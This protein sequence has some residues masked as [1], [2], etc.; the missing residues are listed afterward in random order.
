MFV[1]CEYANI[2]YPNTFLYYVL[3]GFSH[4]DYSATSIDLNA[5]RLCFQAFLRSP[6]NGKFV[7]LEP[8]V[9]DIIYNDKSKL[10]FFFCFFINTVY[11]IRVI[12]YIVKI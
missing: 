10:F 6:T 2:E 5:F 3:A 1:N 7:T 4:R 11:N 12:E 9:S 8:V